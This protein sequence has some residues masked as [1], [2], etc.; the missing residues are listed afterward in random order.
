MKTVTICVLGSGSRGNCVL[1]QSASA[2]ILI[3]AGF[4]AAET[5]RRLAAAGSSPEAIDAVLIGHEHL[6][7]IRGLDVIARKWGIPVY[8]NRETA[9]AA[10]RAAG[11]PWDLR[12]FHNGYPF[13]VEEI[14]V[15]AFSVVHDALDPVGFT[16]E[17]G[18]LKVFAATDLGK[19]TALVRERLRGSRIA[20]IESNHDRDL[21]LNGKRPW[22]LK[23]RIKSSRGHLSNDDAARLLSGENGGKLTD[24]FLAHL[25]RDCNRP[26]MALDRITRGLR[27]KGA[28]GPR[29]HLTFQDRISPAISV[30]EYAV[31]EPGK[32]YL[33]PARQLLFPGAGWV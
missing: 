28:D 16:L 33:E 19:A 11:G 9:E 8:M 10:R 20:V 23:Q 6:D 18:S 26:E 7:H 31:T 21:L 15:T 27:R 30:R 2:S 17:T 13:E 22:K 12:I 4:S 25:S 29:I 32:T 14:S 1:I 24:V 5:A 3:D